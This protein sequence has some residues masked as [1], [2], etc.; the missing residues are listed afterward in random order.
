M[1]PEL[2]YGVF[3]PPKISEEFPVRIWGGAGSS[4]MVNPNSPLKESAVEFLRWLTTKEVQKFLAKNTNNLPSVDLGGEFISSKLNEFL[5][6]AEFTTHPDIWPQNEDS[7][8]IE[9]I[10]RQ[11]QKIII[12]QSTPEIAAKEIQKVKERVS[13]E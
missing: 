13:R 6:N 12:G 9:E 11:M 3:L 8:V 7:R 5:K 4:F 1:N 2:D 10:N